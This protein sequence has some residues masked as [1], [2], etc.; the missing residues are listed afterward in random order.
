MAGLEDAKMNA[1]MAK[2]LRD[3]SDSLVAMSAPGLIL[4]REEPARA[5]RGSSSAAGSATTGRPLPVKGAMRLAKDR[6]NQWS[7]RMTGHGP[8]R[9]KKGSIAA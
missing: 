8:A 5:R 3:A 2:K 7:K 4:V 6:A 1:T 9:T